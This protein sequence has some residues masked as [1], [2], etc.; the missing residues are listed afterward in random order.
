M[1]KATAV[2]NHLAEPLSYS[3]LTE[4]IIALF[5]QYVNQLFINGKQSNYIKFTESFRK[6]TA[7]V[8]VHI[9]F[10]DVLLLKVYG[11]S[12]SVTD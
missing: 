12:A 1:H 11:N 9:F 10:I 4:V 5:F 3:P 2:D 8:S 6:G 7:Q